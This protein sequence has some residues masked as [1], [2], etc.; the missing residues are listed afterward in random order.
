[1]AQC[2]H[3]TTITR[4]GEI[5]ASEF[6]DPTESDET[7]SRRRSF[8]P[9]S[10]SCGPGALRA[11]ARGRPGPA[12]RGRAARPLR[13]PGERVRLPVRARLDPH[14]NGPARRLPRGRPG[15]HLAADCVARSTRAPAERGG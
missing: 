1:M 4:I 10:Y 2:V 7:G 11:R 9:G 14:G 8:R 15:H 6:T 3:P 5:D 12:R 13:W